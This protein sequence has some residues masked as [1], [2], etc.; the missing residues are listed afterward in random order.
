MSESLS[1]KN[2]RPKLQKKIPEN[3]G[4]NNIKKELKIVKSNKNNKAW[5]ILN[6]IAD[7]DIHIKCL[8][9]KIKEAKENQGMI[10]VGD[11]K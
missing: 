2:R 10:M 1:Q 11:E 7:A 3:Y 6:N 4:I 9:N 8:K 5:L